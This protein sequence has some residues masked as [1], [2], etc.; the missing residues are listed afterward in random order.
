MQWARP[1]W[2]LFYRYILHQQQTIFNLLPNRLHSDVKCSSWLYSCFPTYWCQLCT[3]RSTFLVAADETWTIWPLHQWQLYTDGRL[4]TATDQ[5]KWAL[6]HFQQNT[7][8]QSH[9]HTSYIH[10]MVTTMTTI[11]D[12]GRRVQQYSTQP[13]LDIITNIGVQLSSPP[14]KKK[15]PF[16]LNCY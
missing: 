13:T 4:T 8:T 16:S 11:I 2:P 12:N 14:K 9:T 6:N 1:F 5:P 15:L 7:C 3:H 10:N